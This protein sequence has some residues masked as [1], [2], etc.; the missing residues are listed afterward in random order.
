MIAAARAAIARIN[1]LDY[2]LDAFVTAT[3]AR[4]LAEARLLEARRASA[5]P[6]GPLAGLAYALGDL[7]DAAGIRTTCQS[8]L[9]A[10]RV[11]EADCAIAERLRVAGAL[12]VGKAGLDEF[13]L[14]APDTDSPFPAPRNPWQPD[15][16]PGGA[17]GSA[18]AVAS[19]MVRLAIGAD[20][21]GGL[22][23]AAAACGVVGLKPS[24]GL[25]SRRGVQPL[26]WSLDHCGPLAASIA[27]IAAALAV[28]A[29]PDPLDP[30]S[31]DLPAGT[32]RAGLEGGVAGLS[33]ALPDAWH[34][35]EAARIAAVLGAAGARIVPAA[36]P[37]PA[38]FAAAGRVIL[39]AEA[40]TLHR[41][42]LRDRGAGYGR[43][44]F[45]RLAL[46]AALSAADLLQ[47]QRMRRML[48]DAV[49]RVFARHD[50]LLTDPA[51]ALAFNLTGHPALVLPTS[52]DADARPLA[53]QL[54]GR[55]FDEVTLLRAG[56]T[57]ERLG[58]WAA[59]PPP[60]LHV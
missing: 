22:R 45:R 18:A 35:A 56:R 53:V 25:V 55:R 11:P 7:C 8:P 51:H 2:R 57:V 28:I 38:L 49:D 58:G 36:L 29:G 9:R 3:P 13:G 23:R 16:R 6:L 19:G 31:A 40:F 32:Y 24:Y 26:A 17:S 30:T 39:H 33:I 48:A 1:A 44:A 34:S 47:A 42:A 46:G 41:T 10:E 37:D 43:D 21:D 50:A 5:L 14:G 59:A 4:A 52:L 15:E 27:E 54:V 60:P 12:L 20:S